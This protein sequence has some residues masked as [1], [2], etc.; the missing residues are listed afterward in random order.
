VWKIL[1]AAYKHDGLY[2]ENMPNLTEGGKVSNAL[3]RGAN[4]WRLPLLLVVGGALQ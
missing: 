4:S 1:D 3:A 2:D